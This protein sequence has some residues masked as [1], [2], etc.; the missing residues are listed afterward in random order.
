VLSY[1]D[2]RVYF[3]SRFLYLI[4]LLLVSIAT[5]T[6]STDYNNLHACMYNS[7]L[8]TAAAH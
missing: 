8:C 3:S 4:L 2:A 6:T 1:D 5:Q 7:L